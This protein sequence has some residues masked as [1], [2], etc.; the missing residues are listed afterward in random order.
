MLLRCTPRV[1]MDSSCW[2][3]GACV[4]PFC[5]KC[6][7][8]EYMCRE[9]SGRCLQ[10]CAFFNPF[11][12]QCKSPRSVLGRL[13][14]NTYLQL[15]LPLQIMWWLQ[16]EAEKCDWNCKQ[17]AAVAKSAKQYELGEVLWAMWLECHNFLSCQ[18]IHAQPEHQWSQWWE[19]HKLCKRNCSVKG[20][21]L[22]T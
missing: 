8:C 2:I 1:P 17:A 7:K 5:L 16:N 14:S 13:H 20:S 19:L 18:K 21:V 15:S 4:W 12:R 3:F 10:V 6:A 9:M 22:W 11:S